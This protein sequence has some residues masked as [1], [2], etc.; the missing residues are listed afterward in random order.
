M[1]SK[2]LELTI[3]QRSVPTDRHFLGERN[4]DRHHDEDAN[5]KIADVEVLRRLNATP[6]LFDSR[7]QPLVLGRLKVVCTLRGSTVS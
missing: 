3:P 7:E 2:A 4:P 5:S 6:V 1:D